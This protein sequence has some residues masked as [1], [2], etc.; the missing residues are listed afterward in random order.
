MDMKRKECFISSTGRPGGT[1][2]PCCRPKAAPLHSAP[3]NATRRQAILLT[4]SHG[5]S[6]TVFRKSGALELTCTLLKGSEKLQRP[7]EWRTAFIKNQQTT[8]AWSLSTVS[9]GELSA[10]SI[11]WPV[12]PLPQWPL[13]KQAYPRTKINSKPKREVVR[14]TLYFIKNG[15][16][17]SWKTT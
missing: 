6:G 15:K 13:Y 14:R 11:W 8:G 10:F 9:C 5:P 3:G 1:C 2:S 7:P 4:T 16:T 17:L 12:L